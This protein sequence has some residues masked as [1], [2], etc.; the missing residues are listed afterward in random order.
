METKWLTT[1]NL[2]PVIMSVVLLVSSILI[3]F[4]YNPEPTTQALIQYQEK[5]MK[6]TVACA[7]ASIG[8]AAI[9]DASTTPVANQ[10]ANACTYMT[11]STVS[12]MLEKF[13]VNT[14]RVVTFIILIPL[15]A[16]FWILY[17]RNGNKK[18]SFIATRFLIL[19][20]CY[21]LIVPI[22]LALNNSISDVLAI[23]EIVE[24]IEEETK[25]EE[26]EKDFFA[27][28]GDFFSGLFN[29]VTNITEE[30]V[31]W[32]RRLI[33]SIAAFVL[34]TCVVPIITMML[35]WTVLKWCF[36][37]ISAIVSE[38]NLPAVNP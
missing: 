16:L 23:D 26:K 38:T 13:I 33:D 5:A 29:T 19:A 20:M 6:V 14:A 8:L 31:N 37:G 32:L 30:A 7:A 34:T 4:V 11:L 3:S 9:P 24:Q 2:K 22:S 1:R 35:L 15:S 28:A 36:K 10:I 25:E 21:V 18:L 12:I 17:F 27:R